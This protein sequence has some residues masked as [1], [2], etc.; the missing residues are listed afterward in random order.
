MKSEETKSGPL[1]VKFEHN[2]EDYEIKIQ[3]ESSALTVKLMRPADQVFWECITNR[4][5]LVK[6][7]KRWCNC[8][9]ENEIAAF[10]FHVVKNGACTYKLSDDQTFDLFLKLQTVTGGEAV[11]TLSLQRVK[12]DTD[13]Q[14]EVQSMIISDLRKALKDLEVKTKAQTEEYKKAKICRVVPVKIFDLSAGTGHNTSYTISAAAWTDIQSA[15]GELDLEGAA[16]VKLNFYATS[17]YCATSGS[18]EVYF[19]V[20][21]KHK[22][23]GQ[24][25]Y[26][27]GENGAGF[28]PFVGYGNMFSMD[29]IIALEAGKYEAT[30]Q[31]Q[32]TAAT[33]PVSWHGECRGEIKLM[34]EVYYGA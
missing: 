10:I 14:V 27:S 2:G 19:R 13:K 18:G 17:L 15:K 9:D 6:N 3:V 7:N 21:I 32:V 8:V 28:Y 25:K 5:E 11:V 29:D 12:M 26:L 33:Y 4:E 24:I 34:G 31:W 1:S 22:T 16:K 20:V 23:N 30:A